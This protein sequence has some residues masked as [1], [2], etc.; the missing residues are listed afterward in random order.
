MRRLFSLV[1]SACAS[2][3][4]LAAALHRNNKGNTRARARERVSAIENST[5]D[6]EHTDHVDD[7]GSM[8]VH[9]LFTES[10]ST[11]S[12]AHTHTPHLLQ[13][14][15]PIANLARM[16]F[17]YYRTFSI[18]AAMASRDAPGVGRRG[19]RRTRMLQTQDQIFKLSVWTS[20]GFFNV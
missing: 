2:S 13:H 14:T 7:E 17:V 11:H 10:C 1:L 6:Q 12:R 5:I 20:Y 8:V 3:S 18:G 15:R 4:D 19:A 9:A 16:Y